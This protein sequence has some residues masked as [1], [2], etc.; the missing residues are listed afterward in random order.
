MREEGFILAYN[1]R[2]LCHGHLIPLFLHPVHREAAHQGEEKE[3]GQCGTSWRTGGRERAMA[4]GNVC[5]SKCAFG[6]LLLSTVLV[7]LEK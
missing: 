4:I 6:D 3:V 2:V 1:F 7:D 5:S